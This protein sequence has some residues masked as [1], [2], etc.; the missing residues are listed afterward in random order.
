MSTAV[1]ADVT[2][3][4]NLAEYLAMERAATRKHERW[5]SRVFARA[6]TSFAHNLVVANCIRAL[7]NA[8]LHQP[9]VVL[10]SDM[11]V[12]IPAV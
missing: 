2:V 12:R 7:G 6:G 10:P 1:R 8:L 9:C 3:A 4:K 11:K 5:R